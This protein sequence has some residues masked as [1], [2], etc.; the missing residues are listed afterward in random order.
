MKRIFTLLI[1]PFGCLL[2]SAQTPRK[3]IAADPFLSGGNMKVYS[4]PSGVKYTDAPTGYKPCYLSAYARHGSR[5]HWRTKGYSGPYET[6]QKADKAGKLTAT[7]K[8]VYNIVKKL[9]KLSNNH[10]GELT[11]LGVQQHRGIAERMFR[12][13]PEIFKGKVCVTAQS[14]MSMRCALSMMN[15]CWTLQGHN[16]KLKIVANA[17]QSYFK[18]LNEDPKDIVQYR[19]D[20][21]VNDKLD[22]VL[23]K[24][25][26]PDR[27]ISSVFNDTAY[28]SHNIKKFDF[29]TEVWELANMMEDQNLNLNLFKYFT[30]D[31][32]YNRWY[33]ENFCNYVQYGPS[34]ITH[35]FMPYRQ[36]T[37]LRNFIE[38]ADTCLASPRKNVTLR[39]GHDTAVLPFVS[40][41][42]L[43]DTGFQTE[44]AEECATHWQNYRICPM[45]ANIQW[46]FYR[47]AGS[48]DLIKIML[49]EK[50]CTLPIQS[51]TTPY[52]K[53][54]DVRAYCESILEKRPK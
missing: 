44:D 11:K 31:E 12:N 47:K 9:Y 23:N 3:D 6:L 35:N 2:A 16:A 38:T 49:N 1:L 25:V 17:S 34:S 28:V 15:E 43:N 46:V 21:I 20:K 41:L 32:I 30:K 50:E 18:T 19:N 52:Y 4:E 24:V 13:F 54:T 27:F 33:Y 22:A 5:Y 40:L 8:E 14:T 39:F 45:A 7:G 42:R 29:F 51:T 36:T 10:I 26:L 37:L 48:P 53:W